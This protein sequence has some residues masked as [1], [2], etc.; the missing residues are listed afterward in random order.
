MKE[1]FAEYGVTYQN[2]AV[3]VSYWRIISD[4]DYLHGKEISGIIDAITRLKGHLYFYDLSKIAPCIHWHA[5]KY[6]L[7]LTFFE[8]NGKYYSIC[9]KYCKVMGISNIFDLSA[10]TL[11]GMREEF[12]Q[13]REAL[14]D[15]IQRAGA[16]YTA[17]KLD[18]FMTISSIAYSTFKEMTQFERLCP[19]ISG[20]NYTK[21]KPYSR[22]GIV[23]VN[24]EK[25][26]ILQKNVHQ[27]DKNGMY[28][29][30]YDKYP[31]P[32]GY[33]VFCKTEKELN[34]YP[35]RLMKIIADYEYKDGIPNIG[36]RI[37]DG[38]TLNYNPFGNDEVLYLTNY[39]LE[40]AQRCYDFRY[41][42]ICG[43]GFNVRNG[44]YS[45]YADFF[46]NEKE[47]NAYMKPIIKLMLNT[48]AGKSG[49]KGTYTDKEYYIDKNDILRCKIN[50]K[51]ENEEGYNYI[52]F[53]IAVYSIG[54]YELI[55]DA[56]RFGI[57]KENL[58]YTDT[59]SLKFT[60]K[61]PVYDFSR[62]AGEWKDE[63]TAELFK[64]NG[65][66]CYISYT[67]KQIKCTVS[68][69]P[70]EALKRD[71]KHGYKMPHDFAESI[72]NDFNADKRIDIKITS[73]CPGGVKEEVIQRRLYDD[74][75]NI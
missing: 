40:N 43:F 54:R 42:F 10:D 35:F 39:D 72:I 68:G 9:S 45:N 1:Y 27:I 59:D 23:F 58:I 28:S 19:K 18:Q 60:G 47:K 56:E 73:P 31:M 52:P 69:C 65:P 3:F 64:A 70:E 25:Q 33:P 4:V 57:T 12:I 13:K 71:F 51:I 32:I 67:D 37:I 74:S 5:V 50:E 8:R 53:S 34:K 20:R 30:I 62:R 16:K 66:K 49:I 63:G 7:P 55:H 14:K 75:G 21:F 36:K 24:P 46:Q 2:N 44:L 11:E 15:M 26:G 48:P 22:G 38:G 29:N 61:K 41:R 6:N 17:N